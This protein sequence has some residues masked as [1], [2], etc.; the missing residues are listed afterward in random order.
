M[1]R[2]RILLC[3]WEREWLYQVGAAFDDS[4]DRKW[5]REIDR[6]AREGWRAP[7]GERLQASVPVPAK[8]LLPQMSAGSRH[9]FKKAQMRA[10]KIVQRAIEKG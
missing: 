2:K 10:C 8:I 4:F 3:D 5:V 6:R 7:S 9:A 1:E